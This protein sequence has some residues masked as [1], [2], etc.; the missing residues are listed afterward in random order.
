MKKKNIL[1]MLL[2]VRSVMFVLTFMAASAIAGKS[3]EDIS[4]IW[5]PAISIINIVTILLIVIL[6]KRNGKTYADVINYQKGKTKIS[7]V[8]LITLMIVV[9][10][11]AGMMLAGYICYG[12]IPYAAPMIIAPVPKWIALVNFLILPITTAFAEDGLY[13]GCGVNQM[14]NKYAAIL[15]PAFFFALQH[16]FAP[17]L[18]DLRYMA[19]RFLSFLPLTVIL[20]IYYHKKRN[21]IPIL[22]GHA[23][24]DLATSSQIAATSMVDGLYE[25]MCSL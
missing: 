6:A 7:Q 16:C 3:L 20:C 13:L 21:L 23:V 8:I 2:P 19:Y 5:S 25:M 24:V 11:M 22:V 1:P 18:W 14:K 4:N 10:A 17:T 12:V 15:I 9:V